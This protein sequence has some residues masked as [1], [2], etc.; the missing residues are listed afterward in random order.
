MQEREASCPERHEAGARREGKVEEW[1]EE[2]GAS[3]DDMSGQRLIAAKLKVVFPYF[4]VVLGGKWV[5]LQ[6]QA[7]RESNYFDLGPF[8]KNN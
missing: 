5:F 7:A 4:S 1:D 2:R 6:Q 8:E 3:T